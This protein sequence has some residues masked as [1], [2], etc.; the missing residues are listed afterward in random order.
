MVSSANP[1][2]SA[3]FGARDV[4]ANPDG[5]QF[6]VASAYSVSFYDR[7]FNSLGTVSTDPTTGM[8]FTYFNTQYSADRAVLYRE[9]DGSVVDVVN[10]SNF[11]D[12]GGV[13]SDLGSQTQF[14]PELLWVD[15]TQR[16]FLS[17]VGGVGVLSCSHTRT[18][19]P[20][21]NGA[22]GLNPF[23]VPLNQTVTATLN[24]SLPPGTSLTINGQFAPETF[25]NTDTV[26]VEVPA[27]SVAGPV[28]LVFTLPDR[29]TQV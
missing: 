25:S 19:I 20:T 8:V 14:E 16:A 18:G 28:N 11:T 12:I 6:A 26:M 9:L 29:E 2:T 21:I 3:P 13:T 4:A 10:T 5:S 23:A 24:S 15:S 27:S 7:A 1:I 17:A 22:S